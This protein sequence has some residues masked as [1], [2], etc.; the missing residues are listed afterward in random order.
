MRIFN[1]L[2]R[3]YYCSW[4][5]I[6]PTN[7]TAIT[8]AGTGN[9]S[10]AH[11]CLLQSGTASAVSIGSGT[12][13]TSFYSEFGSSNTNVITGAGTLNYGCLEFNQAGVT[14]NTTTQTAQTVAVGAL[15]F[16]PATGTT[17]TATTNIMQFYE[18][19][20]FVPTLL[21]GTSAGATTYSVQVGWYTK[22]GNLCTISGQINASALTGTGNAQLGGI[23]FTNKTA[24]NLVSIGTAQISASGWT[25]GKPC[26]TLSSN[27]G[28]TFFTLVGTGT[29]ANQAA[30]PI[31]NA[32]II[33]AFTITYP[34]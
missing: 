34:V 13:F 11:Y 20:T 26:A 4:T 23:P 24:T 21:G 28:Q 33:L 29:A 22:I 15:K 30:I 17:G 5:E 7:T 18:E 10:G 16:L 8:T 31:T 2:N 9:N 27:S 19:G 1:E 6:N 3:Q 14:V 25:W 32:A 12:V